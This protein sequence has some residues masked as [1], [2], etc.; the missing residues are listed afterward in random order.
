MSRQPAPPS[1]ASQSWY[2]LFA[3]SPQ[4]RQPGTPAG[5]NAGPPCSQPSTPAAMPGRTPQRWQAW[6]KVAVEGGCAEGRFSFPC[7]R[8]GGRWRFVEIAVEGSR[9]RGR[10]CWLQPR[11]PA[12]AAG[13]PFSWLPSP[14]DR[15]FTLSP[16]FRSPPLR[17]PS[18]ADG[19]AASHFDASAAL[20]PEFRFRFLLRQCADSTF[21]RM[22]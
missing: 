3:R 7:R 4:P 5:H 16:P 6:W 2:A 18:T 12:P 11:Q 1:R 8:N 22:S 10:W 15:S 19:A 20:L 9:Q 13:Q 14:A 21:G 17:P